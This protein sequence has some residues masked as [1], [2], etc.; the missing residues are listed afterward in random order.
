[1][2]G[3]SRF[4]FAIPNP[5]KELE[6]PTTKTRTGSDG[7]VRLATRKGAARP[8]VRDAN[9]NRG[10]SAAVRA[11]G[12]LT[13]DADSTSTTPSLTTTVSGTIV[14]GSATDAA[15]QI[16]VPISTKL[17]PETAGQ[18]AFSYKADDLDKATKIKVGDFFTWARAQLGLDT[19]TTDLPATLRD[20]SV[21][22][23]KLEFNTSGKFDIAVEI[24]TESG[25]KF[26]A[27][28]HP[29]PGLTSFAISDVT[30]EVKKEAASTA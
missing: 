21:A 29:I 16:K 26:D 27:S 28:W 2:S 9:G 5:Q 3:S 12:Q 4:N 10:T 22:V 7:A 15:K 18:F 11:A 23:L 25:G 8:A 1:M 30:L 14:I 19:Q 6:M 20:L 17:P 24:G 13:A